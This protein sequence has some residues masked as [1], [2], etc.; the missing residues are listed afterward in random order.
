MMKRRLPFLLAA[1]AGLATAQ[2]PTAHVMPFAKPAGG[3][4][5]PVAT[6]P[7][8]AP[9]LAKAD[10]DAWL[11]GILPYAINTGD[12]AG[13]VVAVVKDGQ[14]VTERGYGYSDVAARKPVDP[15]NTLFRPG[16]TSKLFTWTAV[17][18][19]VEQGKIDL[20][21]DVNTY[22]DFKIPP[23]QA[24]PITMRQI[25]THT[26]GFEEA[27]SGLMAASSTD[28]PPPLE[29]I[30]KKW[31]PKRVYAPGTTPAYSNYAVTLAG[32]IVQRVSGEPYDDYVAHHIFQPLGMGHSTM[33]QPLPANLAP[34][35]SKGYVRASQP[36]MPYEVI[37]FR[38]AGSATVSADDMTR[39][40][41]AH[42]S[43]DQNPLLKP[44]T[45]RM[46][47]DT[48]LTILPMVNRMELGF[49]EANLNGHRIISHGGDTQ[50]FHSD[51]WLLPDDRTGIFFSMNSVGAGVSQ[52]TIRE[53]L[54]EKFMDR[55]FPE[56][57]KAK[58][59]FQPR[60]A[61]AAM[62]AGT[63]AESRASVSGFRKALNFFSQTKVSADATGKVSIPGFFFAGLDGGA[64]DWVEIA[65]FVWKD[66]NSQ[67]KLAAQVVD[68]RVTRLSIDF[69]SPFEIWDRVP[70][71]LSTAWLNPVLA[72]SLAVLL[73][74]LLS[75][76]AGW[77]ARR[78]YGTPRRFVGPERRVYTATA[79]LGLGT[80]IVLGGWISLLTSLKFQ[81]LG[82]G[83]MLLQ[84]A[85][86][87][88]FPGYLILAGWL[89]VL[90]IGA[91]RKWPSIVLRALVLL[92]AFFILWA[93]IVFHLLSFGVDY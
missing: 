22:L 83:T 29:T 60:P 15:R 78:T 87:L 79:L 20:D 72:I 24:K 26:A 61:D 37:T 30:L 31:M 32:Y 55:Y 76:P 17:M 68:G 42:L 39:F 46:M 52:I 19:Q 71:Y 62:L 27:L 81:V 50:W 88:L 58:P 8:T 6:T 5:A 64:R 63:Y 56:T 91:K 11:D 43:P 84:I 10:V 53:A 59:S 33:V 90:G 70:W 86:I 74:L 35:M 66:R 36:A 13:A 45:M 51:L 48:P 65:P 16:S 77:I 7:S 54:I 69:V 9:I 21:T 82:A 47:H 14:V 93:G 67:E 73:G 89:L 23:Y 4:P 75:A 41:I 80:L 38:P 44:Q 34:L 2:V 12:V 57:A 49:Y 18:Q 92:S 40:M 28:T 85:T 3:V 1:W 25:M